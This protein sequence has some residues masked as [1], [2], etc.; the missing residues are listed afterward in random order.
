M[1]ETERAALLGEGTV[2]EMEADRKEVRP[3]WDV[4]D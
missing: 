2:E 1:E 4:E 3:L